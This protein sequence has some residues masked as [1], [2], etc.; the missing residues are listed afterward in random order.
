[1]TCRTGAKSRFGVQNDLS[2]VLPKSPPS[3]VAVGITRDGPWNLPNILLFTTDE[4]PYAI[5][6]EVESVEGN[7]QLAARSNLRRATESC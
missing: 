3:R 6:H 2:T 7:S 5:S 1:M 4:Q